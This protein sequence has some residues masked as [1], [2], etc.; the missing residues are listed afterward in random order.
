MRKYISN[1][2]EIEDYKIDEEL[3]LMINK[4]FE[5]DLNIYLQDTCVFG[6][7]QVYTESDQFLGYAEK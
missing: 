6:L 1:I 7:Y 5:E 4:I 2:E 3:K